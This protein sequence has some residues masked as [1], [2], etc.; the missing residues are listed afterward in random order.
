[1]NS[2]NKI[3]LQTTEHN[4]IQKITQDKLEEN[5]VKLNQR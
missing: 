4:R 2:N 1:M 3:K 5:V